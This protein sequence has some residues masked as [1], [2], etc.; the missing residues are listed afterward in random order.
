[1][2]EKK[3]E[4]KKRFLS[5]SVLRSQVRESVENDLFGAP[6]LFYVLVFLFATCV[7]I[8][9]YVIV[10]VRAREKRGR[11][12]RSPADNISSKCRSNESK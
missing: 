10:D 7:A 2:Q 5:V 1:M 8:F 11:V 12:E 3:N 6:V 4:L 9:I